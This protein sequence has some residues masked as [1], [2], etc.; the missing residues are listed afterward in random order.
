VTECTLSNFL[1]DTKLGGV[2][3]MP[4][5]CATIQRDKDWLEQGTSW[6][7]TKWSAKSFTWRGAAPAGVWAR[8]LL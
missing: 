8:D 4:E 7:S 6:S 3:G 1:D 2:A 5:D